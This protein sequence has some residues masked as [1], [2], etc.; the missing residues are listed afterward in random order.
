MLGA[1]KRVSMQGLK[2]Q[3]VF[4]AQIALKPAA[5]NHY[6]LAADN[7]SSLHWHTA[8]IN[9]RSGNSLSTLQ[10]Q[11]TGLFYT[12]LLYCTTPLCQVF[13]DYM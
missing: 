2:T 8:H 13:Y 4:A 6:G 1:M 12:I 5:Q 7:T 10:M 9:T 3:I 11:I